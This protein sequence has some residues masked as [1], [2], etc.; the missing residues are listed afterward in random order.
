MGAAD[1]CAK[2]RR[3]APDLAHT[4]NTR[5]LGLLQS[6]DQPLPLRFWV[7]HIAILQIAPVP[8]A[9]VIGGRDRQILARIDGPVETFLQMHAKPIVVGDIR[10][11]KPGS[12]ARQRIGQRGN[13]Q[14]RHVVHIE[15]SVSKGHVI[16]GDQVQILE[17]KPPSRSLAILGIAIREPAFLHPIMI[18]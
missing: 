7:Q 10:N 1:K 15:P 2:L 18:L 4:G 6:A 11:E 3:L 13:R 8:E 16:A 9:A 12:P 14:H 17:A 5:Q